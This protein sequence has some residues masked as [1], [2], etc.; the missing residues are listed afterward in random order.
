MKLTREEIEK[1]LK[2]GRMLFSKNTLE[3]HEAIHQAALTS[4]DH[5][6]TLAGERPKA[7]PNCSH[8]DGKGWVPAI[9]SDFHGD[10]KH[11]CFCVSEND[12]PKEPGDMSPEEL[13]QEL[14]EWRAGTIYRGYDAIK[15]AEVPGLQKQIFTLESSLAKVT[16][17]RD[18]YIERAKEAE[19]AVY[20]MQVHG[21]GCECDMCEETRPIRKRAQ[22]AADGK[23]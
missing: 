23:V 19:A 6:A 8:C 5:S 3:R 12:G 11:D 2:L 22:E 20:C 16:A 4:L 7:D 1:S 10:G 17:E 18:K 9:V 21:A 14:A 13:R 15:A